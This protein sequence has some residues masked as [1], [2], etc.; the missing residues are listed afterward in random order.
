MRPEAKAG[1]LDIAP[2]VPGASKAAGHAKPIKLSANEN[3]L[4]CS[5]KARAAYLASADELHLYPDARTSRLRAAIAAKYGLEPERLLFGA[6]SDELF[7]IACMAY[8]GAGDNMVQP[9]YGFAAWAIAAHAAGGAVKS[10]P[11]RNYTVDVDAI[12]ATVDRRTRIVFIANPANPTGT[13]LPFG[14]IERLHAALPGNVLLVLDGAYSECAVGLRG[15]SAGLEWAR[16]KENVLVTRTFSKMYGLASLRIGWGYAP[17]RVVE[18]LD[19]IRLPF[20]ISRGGEAAAVAALEDEAFLQRSVDALTSGRIKLREGLAALGARTLPSAANF[21]TATFDNTGLPAEQIAAELAR[22]G[23]LVR[24]LRNYGMP[25]W[26]RISVGS[27][28]ELKALLERLGLI[29]EAAKARV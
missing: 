17:A 3:P 25:D 15:Y 29:V 10:A 20:S 9:Q 22:G 14:E 24:H 6:G 23:I 26:L 5:E 13:W 12:L 7:S 8:L 21:I 2:Y 4:G 27:E 1:I 16:D 18:A 28:T 11:E 19:R